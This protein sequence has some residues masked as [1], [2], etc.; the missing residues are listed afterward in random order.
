MTQSGEGSSMN[1]SSSQYKR[2]S[3]ESDTAFRAIPN[4][5]NAPESEDPATKTD[6]TFM[7]NQISI[8]RS[9][10]T[11]QSHVF[12]LHRQLSTKSNGS[13]DPSLQSGIAGILANNEEDQDVRG[14]GRVDSDSNIV[15]STSN[16]SLTKSSSTATDK[17]AKSVH[18]IKSVRSVR[19]VRSVHAVGSYPLGSLRVHSPSP[20]RRDANTHPCL[21]SGDVVIVRDMSPGSVFG[22]DATS[23]TIKN[24]GDF[25]GVRDLPPGAHFV[26]GGTNVSSSRNGF[27]IMSAKRAS[28]EFG[29]VHVKHWNT[30]DEILEEEVSTAEVRIQKE[31]LPEI[32]ET[33]KAYS[34][35]NGGQ[36]IPPNQ[37]VHG[38]SLLYA[39]DCNIWHYLTS[40]MKGALLSR[41]TGYEWN[42]WQVSSNHDCKPPVTESHRTE[43]SLEYRKDEVLDFVFPKVNRTFSESTFGRERTEQAMDTSAHV[44]G[45]VTRHC[46]YEDSDEIIGELQFCYI[47][48]M[49]LGNAACQE[50]WA[51]IVKVLFRAYNLALDNPVFFRKVIESI[52]AQFI[53]DD[54]GFDSS[55][56]DHD[57]GL[58]DELK[59]L[60][61]TF[62]SRLNEL[63]LAQGSHIT[64]DQ[65]EVGRAFEELE[66]WLW[67]WGWDLRGNYV[68][69]GKIQLEDGEFVDAELKDFEAEDE[70]GGHN[71]ILK[72]STANN[73][74]GEYAPVVVEFDEEGRESG[75][76]RFTG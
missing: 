39:K 47:T 9:P 45:I 64:G 66:S 23:V 18:S 32:F 75:I 16:C 20:T 69:S 26:W 35:G 37:A 52:H 38:K 17:S 40:C 14:R 54:G 21:K 49:T 33:L 27:W 24:T 19:S 4:P 58:E 74:T 53:Y 61:I 46:S 43:E 63:L 30:Y 10:T 15:E 5:A 72:A 1:S 6:P 62:K 12:A 2:A 22:C 34:I 59:L 71:I 11:A 68:R 29:E 73:F 3:I 28:D 55:I 42:K 48:G 8:Q 13:L 51:N 7:Q 65:S 76:I 60:L 56:L 70:R 67:K 50:Q 31:H 36:A 57:S 25:Y 41:I 44:M